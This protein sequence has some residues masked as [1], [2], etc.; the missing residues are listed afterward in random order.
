MY[1]NEPKILL[2]LGS[3]QAT[4]ILGLGSFFHK[5]RQTQGFYWEILLSVPLS[6]SQK[7]KLGLNLRSQEWSL[8][9]SPSVI[10]PSSFP[11]SNTHAA[12]RGNLDIS[13]TASF[14]FASFAKQATFVLV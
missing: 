6:L 7:R 3:L 2:S 5:V 13:M 12:P 10:I 14:N 9:R 1:A 4:G 8:L 11:F